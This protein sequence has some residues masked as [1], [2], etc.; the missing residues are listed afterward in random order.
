MLDGLARLRE[1]GVAVEAGL[2]EAEARTLNKGFLTR[3]ADGR[4][5]VTLKAAT[6]LDGRI[7]MADG[8][9]RWITG[10]EA[11]EAG[12]LLRARH[13]A[14][15]IGLGTALA[16]KPSLTCRLPGLADRSP[17]RIVA[18][19]RGR[20]PM[21][22]PLVTSAGD[23][24]TW[25][26]ASRGMDMGRELRFRDAGVEVI[27]VDPDEDGRPDPQAMLQALGSQGLTRLLVEGGGRLSARL[28]GAG[29]VDGLEWFRAG[30]ILGA[31]AKAAVGDLGPGRLA[32]RPRFT[33]EGLRAVGSD[34]Q[35]SFSP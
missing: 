22:N 26:L 32:E 7:A 27:L 34:S 13:D 12:H 21:D 23:V 20:L 9:S 24:P 8:E 1:A 3:L 17:I 33:G 10:P 14:I 35:E 19:S 25:L 4:P 16:D 15:M 2:C 31:E 28:L 29:L 6:S 5:M 30:V 18:D 11:R